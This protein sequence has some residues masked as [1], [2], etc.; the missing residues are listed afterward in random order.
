D[1]A[2]HF[3]AALFRLRHPGMR[4]LL[5]FHRSLGFE[6]ARFRDRVRNA[7]ANLLTDAV[8]TGSRERREH[9]LR[10]NL[11]SPRKVVRI[12]FGTDLSRFRPQ[13]E[14]REATRQRL[15]L[16][17]EVF[18]CGAIGHF[19]EEKGLDVVLRGFTELTR[20]RPAVPLALV[21]LGE[22]Q[23][24]RRQLLHSLAGECS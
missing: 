14:V 11:I 21:I 8:V 2:S 6:S 19:G 16:G 5:T 7:F 3:T 10:Q 22:G 24:P 4:V 12:P 9:Y 1:A 13:P 18:V 15:G 23:P 20:R 17:P